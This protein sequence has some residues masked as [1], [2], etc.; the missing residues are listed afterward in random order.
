MHV[1][2]YI[3]H[4]LYRCS[5]Y[6]NFIG[7]VTFKTATP[8]RSTLCHTIIAWERKALFLQ[9]FRL[10]VLKYNICCDPNNKICFSNCMY[11]TCTYYS[12]IKFIISQRWVRTTIF[13]YYCLK[14]NIILFCQDLTVKVHFPIIIFCKHLE[15]ILRQR[16]YMLSIEIYLL[17]LRSLNM[18]ILSIVPYRMW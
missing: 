4:I 10:F 12:C 5:I 7:N 17:V 16:C 13:T 18:S 2:E 11:F 15:N 3:K 14:Y 8:S 1:S 9:L 6:T